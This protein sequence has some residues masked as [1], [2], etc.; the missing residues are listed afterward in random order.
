MSTSAGWRYPKK[1]HPP[2]TGLSAKSAL[3]IIGVV[4]ITL[5]FLVLVLFVL[6][7]ECVSVHC[8]PTATLGATRTLAPSSIQFYVEL[9]NTG[10]PCNKT[11]ISVA[12]DKCPAAPAPGTRLSVLALYFAEYVRHDLLRFQEDSL[13]T[14]STANSC[15]V[16]LNEATPYVDMEQLYSADPVFMRAVLRT[17]TGGTLLVDPGNLAPTHPDTGE[18]VLGDARIA[19]S[20]AMLAFQTLWIR[21]HNWWA[22]RLHT[23]VPVPLPLRDPVALDQYLFLVARRI[24]IAEMQSVVWNEW[25]PALLG[26]SRFTPGLADEVGEGPDLISPSWAFVAA[27]AHHLFPGSLRQW[28]HTGLLTNYT[29]AQVE[30]SPYASGLAGAAENVLAGAWATPACAGGNATVHS[31][32]S[33]RAGSALNATVQ[34]GIKNWPDFG[35]MASS[36]AT[37]APNDTCSSLLGAW[38]QAPAPFLGFTANE[39]I[40]GTFARIRDADPDY[41]RRSE[42]KLLSSSWRAQVD[43]TTLFHIIER[44]FAAVQPGDSRNLF[45]V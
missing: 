6:N 27:H 39:I 44:N 21:E 31:A 18:F 17:G 41:Y 9:C 14:T 45:I 3:L 7:G 2:G 30:L 13:V 26:E 40:R 23:T 36:G 42:N 22:A 1:T 12:D 37:L 16:Y 8:L 25:L 20:S 35:R 4:F 10:A 43:R 32:L 33:G 15:P 34:A 38:G 5:L 28:G 24:V 11:A 19:N 29:L